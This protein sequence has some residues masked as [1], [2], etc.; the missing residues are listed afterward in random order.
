MTNRQAEKHQD[1]GP[2]TN[3]EAFARAEHRR[4]YQH[5][6][7]VV[8]K[9]RDGGWHCIRYCA[10]SIKRAMLAVGTKGR[11]SVLGPQQHPESVRWKLAL[12]YLRNA[13]LAGHG[14]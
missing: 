12:V 2:V 11:F 6:Q 13:R 3:A 9:D 7:S 10:E 14:M 1:L 4:R 8:F 5:Q